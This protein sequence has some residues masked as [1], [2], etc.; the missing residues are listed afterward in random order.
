MAP[1]TISPEQA[2]AALGYLGW[3]RQQLADK[4]GLSLSAIKDFLSGSRCPHSASLARINEVFERPGLVI[5]DTGISTAQAELD[6]L[7]SL[8]VRA[9]AEDRGRAVLLAHQLNN[10][11]G[12]RGEMSETARRIV[13]VYERVLGL[14]K[15]DAE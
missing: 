2:R 1:M 3:S 6:R 10:S 8:G 4:S 9:T 13:E 14:R 11:G 12:R 5:T 7:M 15:D